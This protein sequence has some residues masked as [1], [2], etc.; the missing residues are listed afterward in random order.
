MGTSLDGR[1]AIVT[2]A[3]RNVGRAV[4]LKLAS[5]GASVGVVDMDADSAR[6]VAKEVEASR[7]GAVAVAIAC[8]VTKASEVSAM[9]SEVCDRCGRVD[10]L[11]NNVA[12][13]DRNKTVLTLEQDEWQH[14]F[15]AC[16]TSAFLCTKYAAKQM[17]R[18]GGG[19]AIVN[20]GSTSG[21][22]GRGNATAYPMAK[23]A[24]FGLTRAMA[25]QLGGDGIRVNLVAPNRVGSPV[26]EAE[27]PAN[28]VVRNLLSDRP[29]VPMDIAN[30]VAFLV[31]DEASFV[32][33]V[34]VLVDAGAVLAA[35]G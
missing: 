4:A 34:D 25:I 5:A 23:S 35:H 13:S 12:A 18:Q 20:L 9:V 31:S 24:L 22:L 15:D 16:V 6:A 32:T 29:A 1:V 33:G 21:Y 28:R 11:V 3:G 14:V 26:G 27:V 30:M 10:I 17:A 19:G 7:P 8:D 2:G